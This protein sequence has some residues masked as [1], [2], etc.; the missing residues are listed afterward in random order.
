MNKVKNFFKYLSFTFTLFLVKIDSIFAQG[1][2]DA[3]DKLGEAG[4]AAGGEEYTQRSLGDIVG[5]GIKVVLQMVGLIFLV[6]MVYAGY[7]WMTARG[8]TEQVEKARDI[9]I[10]TMIG[11]FIVLSAYAIT[12]LVTGSL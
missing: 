7:L 1:F 4:K 10:S 5:S 11:L 9:I 6:L 2:Q 8:N 3:A 12:F